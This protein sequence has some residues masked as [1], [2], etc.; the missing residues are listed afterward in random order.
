MNSFCWKSVVKKI[1]EQK[2]CSVTLVDDFLYIIKED[3]ED[4]SNNNFLN[5]ATKRVKCT[6][7]GA[8]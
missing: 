2:I 5:F 6:H 3:E 1:F 8:S 4:A 7:Q